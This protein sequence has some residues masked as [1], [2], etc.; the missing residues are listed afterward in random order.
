[1]K[2]LWIK[3]KDDTNIKVFVALD[4]EVVDFNSLEYAEDLEEIDC[5][6]CVSSI[7]AVD[8]VVTG[9]LIGLRITM[10]ESHWTR[11][12]KKHPKLNR[13]D[14]EVIIQNIEV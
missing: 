6:I 4:Y 10:N 13:V 11:L 1:M 5:T 2:H 7:H 8:T 9:F 3:E 12:I 14:V